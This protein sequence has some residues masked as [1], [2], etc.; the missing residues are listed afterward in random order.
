M[1]LIFKIKV[2]SICD[3]E[4][5]THIKAFSGFIRKYISGKG[6]SLNREITYSKIKLSN[7]IPLRS[8]DLM[9]VYKVIT[10]LFFSSF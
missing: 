8:W 1:C 3:L 5:F 10:G 2:F 7:Y 6:I 9:N 4:S